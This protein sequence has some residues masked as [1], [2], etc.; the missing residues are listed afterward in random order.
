MSLRVAYLTGRAW[1]GARLAPGALPS[2]EAPDFELMR[3]AGQDA[4]VAF[5]IAYWDDPA[6]AQNGFD[7]ALVRSCWDYPERL[8]DFIATLEAHERAG[9][10][11][12]NDSATVRW[13]ARKT[14]LRDLEARGVPV[15]PTRWAERLDSAIVAHAFSDFDTAELVVK[16]QVGAGSRETLRLKRNAWSEADLA[17]GPQGP[18]MAQPF[19]PTIETDGETSL[20]YFGGAFS[21]AI[22]KRP[23]EGHWF[24][25]A[26]DARF[27][28]CDPEPGALD[29]AQAALAAA[30]R[31]FAYVRVDL[32]RGAARDW[33]VIELEAIEPFLFLAFAPDGAPRFAAALAGALAD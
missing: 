17:L 23:A 15:I 4:G 26:M 24:A 2:L 18:A 14:Y 32:V 19:L 29:V 25:N 11:I 31:D 20:F 22:H 27:A 6:L 21:H 16:P 30:E 10:R 33:R 7:A 8:S 5:E 3:E 1:R 9:L 28:R 13:N 12:L